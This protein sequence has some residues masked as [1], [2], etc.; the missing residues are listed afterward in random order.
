M[1]V[2]TERSGS[3]LCRTDWI[4][5][6]ASLVLATKPGVLF[7]ASCFRRPEKPESAASEGCTETTT[8]LARYAIEATAGSN[9]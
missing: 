2:K 3:V 8:S 9:C 1:G 6:T 7:A 5:G 4:S